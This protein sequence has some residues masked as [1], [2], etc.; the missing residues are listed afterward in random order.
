MHRLLVTTLLVLVALLITMGVL[1]ASITGKGRGS[2]I[3]GGT[4]NAADDDFST[5][6]GGSRNT[7]GGVGST[8][9][10]GGVSVEGGGLSFPGNEA[11]VDLS[12][13]GGGARN[14]ARGHGSTVGGGFNN[15]ATPPAAFNP[16]HKTHQ[17]ELS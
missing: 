4:N 5:V 10:G 3:A 2:T 17:E 16:I 9:S 1:M 15:T 8:V 7:A 11:R 12:T 6:G 14:T 13:V